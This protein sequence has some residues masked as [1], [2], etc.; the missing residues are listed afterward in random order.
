MIDTVL[1][2]FVNTLAYLSPSR[3]KILQDFLKTKNIVSVDD[4]QIIKAFLET[5]EVK[6]YSSVNIKNEQERAN[7]YQDYNKFL[8]DK[9]KLTCHNDF[10]N[11]YKKTEKEW[12]LFDDVSET[13]VEL[14]RKGVRVGIISN[15]D[16][17]LVSAS[18]LCTSNIMIFVSTGSTLETKAQLLNPSARI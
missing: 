8:F 6:H 10:Y 18:R 15:F 4:Q 11:Y 12:V 14:N 3:E 17:N 1:F 13:L 16:K 9:L 5:D 7:F 2:D